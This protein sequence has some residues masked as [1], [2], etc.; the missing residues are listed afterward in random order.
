MASVALSQAEVVLLVVLAVV[1][2]EAPVVLP[3]VPSEDWPEEQLICYKAPWARPEASPVTLS[4]LLSTLPA[5]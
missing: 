5:T 4:T 3:A 2:L 1:L